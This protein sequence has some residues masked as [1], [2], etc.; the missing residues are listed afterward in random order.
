MIINYNSYIFV[1][2]DIYISKQMSTFYDFLQ[3]KNGFFNQFLF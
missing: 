3:L 1:K 2:F